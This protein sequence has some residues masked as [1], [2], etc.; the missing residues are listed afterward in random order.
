GGG[1]CEKAA[2]GQKGQGRESGQ[3]GRQ[4]G[5]EGRKKG[6][7][8]GQ[9]E[10]EEALSFIAVRKMRRFLA[11]SAFFFAAFRSLNWLLDKPPLKFPQTIRG[12]HMTIRRFLTLTA[13]VALPLAA[14]A[15]TPGGAAAPPAPHTAPFDAFVYQPAAEV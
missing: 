4:K 14:S 10:G 13:L 3:E 2:Q 7:Q 11:G 12:T 1:A 5:Q 8:E 15:Q 9:E 6:S